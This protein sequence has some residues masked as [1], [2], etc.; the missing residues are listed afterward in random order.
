MFPF[1]REFDHNW[2][3]LMKFMAD[4]KD[5]DCG[6]HPRGFNPTTMVWVRDDNL[7]TRYRSVRPFDTCTKSIA[8]MT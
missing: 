4:F 1:N 2:V 7:Y 5:V 6:R 8:L 3:T